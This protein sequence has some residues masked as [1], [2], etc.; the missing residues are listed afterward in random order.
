MPPTLA[1]GRTKPPW[2]TPAECYLAWLSPE[3]PGIDAQASFGVGLDAKQAGRVVLAVG[4]ALLAVGALPPQSSLLRHP[5]A[6]RQLWW[7]EGLSRAWA[8][9]TFEHLG[10]RRAKPNVVALGTCLPFEQATVAVEW[11]EVLDDAVIFQLYVAPDH[12][13][14]Y[15]AIAVPS[16]KASAVDDTG[17][18]HEV[19][20]TGSWRCYR[21]EGRDDVLLWLP[22][23]GDVR[24]LSLEVSTLWE[25]AWVEIRG[26]GA[27]SSSTGN[28][29]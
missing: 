2:T 27:L 26:S 13:G 17:I 29:T 16:F 22:I 24:R 10:E 19:I 14:E 5:P 18:E 1:C 11:L 4:D 7:Q 23:G 6:S 9:R 15:W 28:S 8:R 25:A 20:G 12:Q 21:G 3:L